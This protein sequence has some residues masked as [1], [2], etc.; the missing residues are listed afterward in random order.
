MITNA[1]SALNLDVNPPKSPLNSSKDGLR[2]DA[3]RG[4]GRHGDCAHSAADPGA[5]GSPAPDWSYDARQSLTATRTEDLYLK[6]TSKDGDVLEMRSEQTDTIRYDATVSI[7]ADAKALATGD[8]AE[9]APL[10]ADAADKAAKDAE[11]DPKA[12]QLKVI[13]KNKWKDHPQFFV[14]NGEIHRAA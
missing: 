5:A 6:Y 3:P 14:A 8:A 11:L 1:A 2:S 12:Q 4:G 10:S 13:Q 7:S 9:H